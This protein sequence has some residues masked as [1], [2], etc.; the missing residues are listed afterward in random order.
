MRAI[1]RSLCRGLTVTVALTCL[2]LILG[3]ESRQ[4]TV[5]QYRLSDQKTL[6]AEFIVEKFES[7]EASLEH[8]YIF[9]SEVQFEGSNRGIGAVPNTPFVDIIAS[10]RDGRTSNEIYVYDQRGGEI[11]GVIPIDLQPS[12]LFF[13][14]DPR[15]LYAAGFDPLDNA[16]SGILKMDLSQMQVDASVRFVDTQFSPVDVAFSEK[17]DRLYMGSMR[18]SIFYVI[19]PDQMTIVK[20][21]PLHG[22]V[23][24]GVERMPGNGDILLSHGFG[25]GL[26][27]LTPTAKGT[28]FEKIAPDKNVFGFDVIGSQTIG[29]DVS[30]QQIFSVDVESGTA[31]W[32]HF[33]SPA[34]FR[35]ISAAWGRLTGLNPCQSSSTVVGQKN[36]PLDLENIVWPGE[37]KVVGSRY[38]YLW[39]RPGS[40]LC[41]F[42]ITRW[43]NDQAFIDID[44]EHPLFALQYDESVKLVGVGPTGDAVFY[45]PAGSGFVKLQSTGL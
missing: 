21:I 11:L 24:I 9:A 1:A 30:R 34:G 8:S 3:C 36:F 40:T 16:R 42:D 18:G 45:Y 20:R 33:L 12:I 27:R 44:A 25:K 43:E 2:I 7:S 29:F 14:D 5:T 23:T 6:Q 10:W 31:K 32:E 13:G 28:Q 35:G 4:E 17:E 22:E 15:F 38:V 26:T 39:R 37:L 19:D 41:G